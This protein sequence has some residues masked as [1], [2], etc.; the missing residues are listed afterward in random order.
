MFSLNDHTLRGEWRLWWRGLRTKIDPADRSLD[1]CVE[2]L[3]MLTRQLETALGELSNAWRLELDAGIP[4]R[5]K[6]GERWENLDVLRLEPDEL[7]QVLATWTPEQLRRVL[8][9][10][11]ATVQGK[12]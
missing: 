12:R 2:Q 5:V 6:R 3:A 7:D 11:V 4:F 1:A 9:L 8:V 10:V